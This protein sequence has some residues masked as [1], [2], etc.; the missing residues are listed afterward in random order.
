MGTLHTKGAVN[1]IDRII[2]AFP[3]DQQS[4]V[5]IQLSAVLRTVVSQQLL[6]DIKG[7]LVPAFEILHMTSAVRSMIRDCKSHQVPAA[8]ASGT[9]EG[10]LSMDQS[11]LDLLK[12]GC[13]TKTTALEYADNP[14]Q[15]ARRIE[16]L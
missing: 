1:S 4:Q 3:A 14:D 7:G 2:D 16:S 8:I 15:M 10:M 11:I 13:I 5:R 12:K 6:P 9:G